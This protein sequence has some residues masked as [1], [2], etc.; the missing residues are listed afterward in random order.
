MQ[1]RRLGQSGPN[2]GAIAL[3]CMSFGG[4]YGPTDITESHETL[5]FARDNGVDHLDT[6]DVYGRG[7][8]EEVIGAFLKDNPHSFKV[9]TKGGIRSGP[10]RSFDNSPEYL[11]SALEASLTRLGVDYVD[12]YYVHRR[13]PDRPIEDVTETLVRFMDEGKIGGFGFSEISPASLTRAAAIHP[14]MAVQSEYSLWTRLP[15]LGLIQTCKRL[16]TTLVPFSPLARGMFANTLPD[17]AKFSDGDFRRNNPRFVEPNFRRNGDFIARFG[18]LA[19]GKGT[20]PAALALAWILAKGDH[21]IPIPGTR[22]PAHL[23]QNIEGAR[24]KLNNT[25]M[26]EIEAV[27][28]IGFAHGARYSDSQFVGPENYC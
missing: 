6:A 22:S 26:D 2:V 14:V 17:P 4:F 24:L 1:Q 9:A 25:D 8:S 21:L 13:Q 28:P 7:V 20:T 10:T 15:E 12:L 18:A 27:L 5:A 19:H 3:G 11:R 23:A 16:G